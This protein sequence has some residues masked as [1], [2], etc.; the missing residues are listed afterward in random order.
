MYVYMTAGTFEFLKK[1]ET[2]YPKENMITMMNENGALLLHES[3]G[4]TV[5]KEPRRYEVL[6]T[7]G[8]MKKEGYAVMNNIPV[9]EEGRPLFE[10]QFKNRYS[11]FENEQGFIALRV[12]RPL[13][14]NTYVILTVWE[15]EIYYQKWQNSESFFEAHKNK[16]AGID[17]QPKIFAS[18]A[19][20]SKYT[21]TE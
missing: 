18:A 16:A 21:I 20:V 10:H 5:F 4:A 14:S 1:V 7:S 6:E 11:K 17:L 3:I 19:Y 13:S 8:E 15:K 12:L 9:T 2:K